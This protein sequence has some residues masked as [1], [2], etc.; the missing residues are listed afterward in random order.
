MLRLEK[1]KFMADHARLYGFGL[2]LRAP[3]PYF[4]KKGR[5]Q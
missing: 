4:G 1:Q 5:L 3:Q 2:V